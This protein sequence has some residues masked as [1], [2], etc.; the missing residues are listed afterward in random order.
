MRHVGARS[1]RGPVARRDGPVKGGPD[2]VPLGAR[3][4]LTAA[5]GDRS[6][7]AGEAPDHSWK[8]KTALHDR[9]LVAG[10]GAGKC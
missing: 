1:G 10:Q 7:G 4:L 3:G 5:H 2:D 8:T 9:A 6:S